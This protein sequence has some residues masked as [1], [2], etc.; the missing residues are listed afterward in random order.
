MS[1]N[2]ENERESKHHVV[3]AMGI[4]IFSAP[5]VK[6]AWTELVLAAFAIQS[7][8]CL[9]EGNVLFATGRNL[10]ISGEHEAPL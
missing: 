3:I 4:F 5:G 10:V 2:I 1:R 6:R 9:L 8:V 7:I